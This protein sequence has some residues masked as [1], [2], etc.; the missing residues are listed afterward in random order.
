MHWR[1]LQQPCGLAHLLNMYHAQ[2]GDAREKARL[3][4]AL[5]HAST[6]E[7][8]EAALQ[9]ALGPD[10]KSQDIDLISSVASRGGQSLQ[11]AW[12]FFTQCASVLHGKIQVKEGVI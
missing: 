11:L 5:A 2:A 9:F 8:I 7:T 12:T 3:L 6:P 10:V 1:P 4:S